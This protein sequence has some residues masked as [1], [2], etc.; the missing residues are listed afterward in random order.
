MN[1]NAIVLSAGKGSRMECDIAKCAYKVLDVPMIVRIVEELNKSIVDEIILVVG[2]KKEEI[3]SLFPNN[4]VKFAYQKEQKGTADAVKSA[5]DYINHDNEITIVIPG[6]IPFLSKDIINESIDR[7]ISLNSDLLIITNIIYNST[8][9][10]RIKRRNNKIISI[11]EESNATENEKLI[12]EVNT[13]IMI[14]KTSFLIDEIKNINL[15]KQSNEYYL[16]DILK[17]VDL[18]KVSTKTYYN[19]YRLFG[20]NDINSINILENKFKTI[21]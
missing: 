5:I 12:K 17:C 21:Q 16:T 19:E 11:V 6:D 1:I 20:V 3:I 10:G 15:N 14:F 8:G 2:Y 13:G 9:Y 18:S 4:E 7:F